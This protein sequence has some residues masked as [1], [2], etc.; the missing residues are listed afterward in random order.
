MMQP[1][2]TKSIPITCNSHR[3]STDGKSFI[4]ANP[5]AVADKPVRSHD[6]NVRS[7]AKR[8]RSWAQL[9][10]SSTNDGESV[11]FSTML[12]FVYFRWTEC[13]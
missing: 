6:A 8:V 13:I 4:S 7:L 12:T 1:A 11:S 3:G 5:T 2:P 10:C 9:V